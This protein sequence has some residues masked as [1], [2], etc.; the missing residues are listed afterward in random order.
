MWGVRVIGRRN[1]KVVKLKIKGRK[2]R[3]VYLQGADP[4]WPQGLR[5][6]SKAVPFAGIAGSNPT[7]D[8]NVSVSVMYC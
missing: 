3:S 7:G 8:M 2:L 5:R 1:P 4:W 6:R